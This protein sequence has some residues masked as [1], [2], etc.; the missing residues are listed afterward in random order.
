[1]PVAH[2]LNANLEEEYSS[3]EQSLACLHEFDKPWLQP[4]QPLTHIA[5]QCIFK[6]CFAYPK[7]AYGQSKEAAIAATAPGSTFPPPYLLHS[8]ASKPSSPRASL[9]SSA[10]PKDRLTRV[11]DHLQLKCGSLLAA[12]SYSQAHHFYISLM[13]LMLLSWPVSPK[14]ALVM[15]LPLGATT[16]H[17]THL[18]CNSKYGWS[19]SGKPTM[20]MCLVIGVMAA[21]MITVFT[22]VNS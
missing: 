16:L 7:W 14:V 19:P 8:L 18:Q 15:F 9:T 21:P 12:C 22:E 13:W 10:G 17:G 5:C 6:L 4:V 1:M 2:D 11:L 3:A 20:L